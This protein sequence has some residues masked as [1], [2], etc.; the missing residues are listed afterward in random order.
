MEAYCA[1][2]KANREIKNPQ[3]IEIKDGRR[4]TKG[5]CPVCGTNM[6]RIGQRQLRT[7]SLTDEYRGAQA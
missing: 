2:C 3:S 1:K 5:V 7:L 4:A 6:L